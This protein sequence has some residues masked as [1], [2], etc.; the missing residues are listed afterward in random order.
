M[1]DE[2]LLHVLARLATLAELLRGHPELSVRF[3]CTR[4]RYEVD[5]YRTGPGHT[6]TQV[7]HG[8]GPLPT[9]ALTEA[10][11]QLR[12]HVEGRGVEW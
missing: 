1:S 5:A 11:G 6:P 9:W 8:H 2:D 3:N 12:G 7:A 4:G 10:L